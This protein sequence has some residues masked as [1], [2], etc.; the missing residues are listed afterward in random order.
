M[1]TTRRICTGIVGATVGLTTLV[2][3]PLAAAGP[4]AAYPVA[5]TACTADAPYTV[6]MRYDT[7]GGDQTFVVPPGVTAVR[8]KLWGAGGGG[9]EPSP[10]SEQNA[11]GSGGFTVGTLSVTPGDNLRLV[12]G[13]GGPNAATVPA[14]GGGGAAGFGPGSP[15]GTGGGGGGMSGIFASPG[16]AS[17]L[18]VAGGGG[19]GAGASDNALAGVGNAGGGAGGGTAGLSVP[20]IMLRNGGGGGQDAGGS[21]GEPDPGAV[22]MM[23]G[24]AGSDFTGGQGADSTGDPMSASGGG[25]GGGYR[26]GGGGACS[27][28]SA[29]P[30]LLYGGSGGGGSGFVAPAVVDGV[31]TVGAS[32]NFI[33]DAAQPPGVTEAQYEA[34]I[35]TGSSFSPGG[36]GEIVLEWVGAPTPANLTSTGVGTASQSPELAV[37]SGD[38]VRLVDG[39]GNAVT[40]LTVPGQG[41]Y[42]VDPDTNAISFVPSYGFSGTAT[43]VTYRVTD[44][45]L[46]TGDATYTAT[47][48]KPPAPAP[49]PLTST[50]SYGAEQHQQISLP[51][52]DSVH[53]LS[54]GSP[55]TSV[56][57]GGQ[58]TYSVDPTRG[59]LTFTPVPGFT[60]AAQ[61]VT[62]RVTDG[63]GQ[64]GDAAYSAS[65]T[66]GVVASATAPSR[67]VLANDATTVPV[68]CAVTVGAVSRCDVTGYFVYGGHSYVVGSGSTTVRGGSPRAVQVPM[69]LNA[70]GHFL[71]PAVGGYQVRIAA[72]VWQHANPTVLHAQG[73]SSVVKASV[74]AP[75]TVVFG[76]VSAAFTPAEVGYL[77]SL[78]SRLDGVRSMTC[79]GGSDLTGIPLVDYLVARARAAT[80]CGYLSR[81]T[82]IRTVVLTTPAWWFWRQVGISLSY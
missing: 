46:R 4:A 57:V 66:N 5:T 79:L 14:Y 58:G 25:G 78:R 80:V 8:A 60:G 6:C 81:G 10:M 19:G 61:P 64:S 82:H 30:D 18:L 36:N 29:P 17:P 41:S 73:V 59:L 63:Y 56:S 50:G 71:S 27:D 65:V 2:V 70:L 38:S 67:V 7:T 31:T 77:N 35:G 9:P 15:S 53:L 12:V 54:G 55:V 22:C 44:S 76:P 68:T 45:A 52:G 23:S 24:Q 69:Q 3:V 34:G 11:G 72:N 47:V 75:H 26:G 39:N 20:S 49:A 62:F 1:N 21:G 51:V 28:S 32:G 16:T 48:T 33:F 13:A 43:P 74:T 42:S 37:P 40:T